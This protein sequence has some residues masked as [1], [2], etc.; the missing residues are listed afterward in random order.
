MM[1]LATTALMATARPLRCCGAAQN[2]N[3]LSRFRRHRHETHGRAMGRFDN[4]RRIV[5]VV[6][7]P[8]EKRLHLH[9]YRSEPPWASI[10]FTHAALRTGTPAT[11]CAMV[12][13]G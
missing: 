9:Q 1:S 8:M 5:Y 6:L 12:S 3:T 13:C 10:T 4:C 2:G 7:L 11:S